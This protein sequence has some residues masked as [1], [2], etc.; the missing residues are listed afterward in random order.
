[1]I[2]NKQELRK[3]FLALRSAQDESTLKKSSAIIIKNLYDREEYKKAQIIMIYVSYRGEVE[4]HSLIKAALEDGKRVCVP[5][6][7]SKSPTMTAREIK[8]LAELKSGAYGILEPDDNSPVIAKSEI[9]F[10]V[11]PGCAFSKSGHRI[12]YGKGYY[13]RFLSDTSAVKC[14]LCYDFAFTD[15]LPF[16]QTDIPLDMII[17]ENNIYEPLK[18]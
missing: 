5:L 6:C 13:D 10:V 4:T 11:V 2:N 9:D 17:T 18:P 15:E 12:G 14:G 8:S 16:E 3:K 7:D 1:M